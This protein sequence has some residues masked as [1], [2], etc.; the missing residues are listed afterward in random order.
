MSGSIVVKNPWGRGKVSLKGRI[1][2]DNEKMYLAQL[3]NFKGKTCLKV[4]TTHSFIKIC[5]C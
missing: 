3:V 2:N 4:A 1:L 5:Y